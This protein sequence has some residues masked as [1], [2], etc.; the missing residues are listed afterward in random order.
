MIVNEL[1]RRYRAL[2]TLATNAGAALALNA[3]PEPSARPVLVVLTAPVSVDAL[4]QLVHD[5]GA[6]GRRIVL[7]FSPEASATVGELLAK[8][9]PFS[10][11]APVRRASR[12]NPLTDDHTVV[13]V[14][15]PPVVGEQKIVAANV[16][17]T[18]GGEA[19]LMAE[20]D[21]VATTIAVGASFLTVVGSAEALSDTYLAAADN[22]RWVHWALTGNWDDQA[23]ASIKLLRLVDTVEHRLPPVVDGHDFDLSLLPAPTVAIGSVEFMRAAGRATRLLPEAVHDALIDF[24]DGGDPSGALL[25]KG[26]PVGDVGRTP[27]RPCDQPVKDHVSE[28]VLLTIARRLGQPVGYQPEHGGD[29]IQNICPTKG[30]ASCQTSTSSAVTLM[31]HTEAAFHPHRPA[32][33]LLLCIRGDASA[34]TTLASIHEV[35]DALPLATRAVLFEPRFRTAV[36]DSYVGGRS[37]RLGH[38][39]PVLSG[40]PDRPSMV[41]DADLMIGVDREADDAL[42]MVRTTVQRFHASVVLQA[43]DLLII[44]NNVAVHGR[45]PFTPRFDGT[46]RWLQRAFVV[47]ELASSSADRSGRVILTRFGA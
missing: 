9:G 42:T 37:A 8:L 32:Y 21:T 6:A 19:V 22:A 10:V 29:V 4:H 39:R 41:F 20:G 11:G 30:Q 25:V 18:N 34:V 45:S 47:P 2:A 14:G 3:V 1:T 27:E 12:A 36:D 23:A 24:M 5:S 40:D 35:I 38:P 7:A 28:L 16:T 31:F 17:S 43:G 15:Q 13:A 26:L 46:D 33:L 44:D